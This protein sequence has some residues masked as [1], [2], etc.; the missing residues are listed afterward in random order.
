[1]TDWLKYI[2]RYRR[3]E[4]HSVKEIV[5]QKILPSDWSEQAPIDEVEHESFDLASSPELYTPSRNKPHQRGAIK[6]FLIND[7][8]LW[9]AVGGVRTADGRLIT[10]SFFDAS[11]LQFCIQKGYL[12]QFPLTHDDGVVATIGHPYRNYYH[13][14]ADSIPRVHALHHPAVQQFSDVRLYLDDRFSAAERA[15]IRHLIP[16][17]VRLVETEA[18]VRIQASTYIHLPYLSTD[19]TNFSKWFSASAGFC[20]IEY[21]QRFRQAAYEVFDVDPDPSYRKL[22]VT[23]RNAKVRRLTNEDEVADY[24]SERGFDVVALET[25]PQREQIKRFAEAQFVV[26][27]HGAGLT[28]LLYA[29]DASVLEIMSDEDKLIFYRLISE[30]LGHPHRQLHMDGNNKNDDVY[31]PIGRLAEALDEL[32]A[33]SLSIKS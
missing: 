8:V 16:S 32:E 27:Q 3:F 24:L 31:L 29:R 11:S 28:N 30:S 10:E 2:R 20:P 5:L 25:L 4:N 7:A 13:R 33:E 21:L 15:I 22:Y 17:N 19:R 14:Y 26:A 12:K 23:R 18:P 1:M 6:G 9:P